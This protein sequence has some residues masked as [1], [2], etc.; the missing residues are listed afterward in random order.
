[1]GT[2]PLA[3]ERSMKI[4]QFDDG[5]ADI[6]FEDDEVTI[7]AQKKK[8]HLDAESLR[9]FGNVLVKIVSDWNMKFNK[10]IQQ[11]D[12]KHTTHIKFK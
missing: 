4:Q 10:D 1:M 5:S 7:L 11:K 6:I 12:T 9:H 2:T 8:L 3:G